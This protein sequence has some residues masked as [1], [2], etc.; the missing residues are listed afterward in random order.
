METSIRASK[1]LAIFLIVSALCGTAVCQ[2]VA[3]FSSYH[4]GNRYDF[5]LTHEELAKTPAWNNDDENPP[6][7]VRQAK[8]VGA[9]SLKHL[10]ADAEEWRMNEIT[11]HPIAD[12]WVYTISFTEPPPPGCKDCLAFPFV[13]VVR[14]DGVAVPA[15]VSPWPPSDIKTATLLKRTQLMRALLFFFSAEKS[16]HSSLRGVCVRSRELTPSS[17]F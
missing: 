2:Q 10:F 9:E 7:S 15:T 13:V 12:R 8:V 16:A 14:M 5:R 1:L 4:G 17:Q 6:L 11:L 3:E